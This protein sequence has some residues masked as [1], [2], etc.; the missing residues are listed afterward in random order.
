MR[1]LFVLSVL[2]AT[3]CLYTHRNT[4]RFRI[5]WNLVD[6]NGNP[7]PTCSSHKLGEI[8]VL[9]T[10][11]K[12]GNVASF[13]NLCSAGAVLSNSLPHGDYELDIQALGSYAELAGEAKVEGT[14]VDGE[15]DPVVTVTIPVLPPAT[16]MST[17]WVLTKQGAPATCASLNDPVIQVVMTPD[18]GAGIVSRI[19]RCT[20]T[21]TMIDVPYGP[22]TVTG[23]LADQQQ[24]ILAGAGPFAISTERGLV[25]VVLSFDLP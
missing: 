22:F 9:A 18:E 1:R 23:M 5:H 25:S 19:W 2:L 7:G 14:L 20:E 16:Q 6:A 4:G 24:Q 17:A 13:S 10:N 15:D 11:V 21:D 12:T 8:L 3:S